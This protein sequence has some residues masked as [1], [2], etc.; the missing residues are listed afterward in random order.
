LLPLILENLEAGKAI[1]IVPEHQQLTTERAADILGV[2]RLHF[3]KLLEDGQ[4]PF[5]TVGA[6]RRIDFPGLLTYKDRRNIER[7]A[8]L[9]EIARAEVEAGTY[10]VVILPEAAEDD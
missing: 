6:D 9:D 4:I 10:D 8:A 3:A 2:S 1:S 5:H 7:R